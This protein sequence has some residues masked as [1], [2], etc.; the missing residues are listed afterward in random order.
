MK[1]KDTV[2]NTVF[3]LIISILL[4]FLVISLYQFSVTKSVSEN[5]NI[6]KELCK[7]V[8]R[9]YF[10]GQRDAIKGDIRIEMY[11]DSVYH[12]KKSPWNDGTAPIYI[13]TYLDSHK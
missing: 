12:W 4:I 2:F 13:P 7:I 5:T 11:C 10:E 9:A 8:E 6:K 1:I 3:G